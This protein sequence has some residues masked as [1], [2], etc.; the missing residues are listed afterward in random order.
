MQRQIL[1]ERRTR[2]ALQDN[3]STRGALMHLLSIF[4]ECLELIETL[5]NAK[6]FKAA[7]KAGTHKKLFSKLHTLAC[8]SAT[9]V[10]HN[11][12]GVFLV[13]WVLLDSIQCW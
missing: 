10:A 9:F 11:C 8:L 4:E 1:D 3:A 5:Q 6:W 2:L 13:W 7:A 12:N